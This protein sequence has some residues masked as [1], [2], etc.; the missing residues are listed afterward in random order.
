MVTR[1]EPIKICIQAINDSSSSRCFTFPGTNL[2]KV[3]ADLCVPN[4]S[5]PASDPYEDAVRA[6]YLA[7]EAGDGAAASA[8]VVPE[9]RVKGPFSASELSRFYGNMKKPLRLIGVNAAAEHHFRV[10]YTFE[11][12]DGR[13]CDGLSFVTVIASNGGHLISKI[14]AES[15][16]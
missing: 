6:F 4:A 3:V 8:L 15:G 1:E 2:R 12:N 11:T 5:A 14:R 7:L 10:R 16:C 9:K 13:V